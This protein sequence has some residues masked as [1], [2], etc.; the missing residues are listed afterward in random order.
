MITQTVDP[1][2]SD[3]ADPRVAPGSTFVAVVGLGGSSVRS[4]QRCLP[5]TYPYGCNG[6]WAKI[7]TSN[8]GATYGALFITFNVAGDPRKATAYFKNISG[9]VVDQFTVRT[10]VGL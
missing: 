9:Q 10:E 2:A 6:E 8:Q 3:P 4:Q 1:A 7:Y 5:E